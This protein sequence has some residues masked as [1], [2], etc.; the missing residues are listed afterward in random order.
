M[1][2]EERVDLSANLTVF[3]I[4][5]GNVNYPECVRALEAQSCLFR[6]CIIKDVYPL[7]AAFQQMIL[8]CDTRYYI[9]V[10]EDMVLRPTAV[11]TMYDEIVAQDA[12]FV[13]FP[14]YDPHLDMVI[15]GIKIYDFD[16]FKLFPYDRRSISCE[17]EQLDRVN[18]YGR[19]QNKC[20]CKPLELG[21]VVGDHSPRWEPYKIYQRYRNL[22]EKRRFLP[23]IMWVD[24]LLPKFLKRFKEDPSE[25]NF[26]ALAGVISGLTSPDDSLLGE[27]DDR[28]YGRKEFELIKK[29]YDGKWE[30]NYAKD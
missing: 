17:K 7:D 1:P 13:A 12:A 22:T 8:Q 16:V 26:Y 21:L 3:V 27:R 25:L 5:V 6:L 30:R 20:I 14:L 4:T 11:K 10:D 19:G 23:W 24:E 9:Q 2:T 15:S 28:T 29:A 18:W